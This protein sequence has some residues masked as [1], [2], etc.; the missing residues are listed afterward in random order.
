MTNAP[1]HLLETFIAILSPSASVKPGVDANAQRQL[2]E[3]HLQQC[4]AHPGSNASPPTG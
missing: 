4:H 1:A 2:A 3:Q